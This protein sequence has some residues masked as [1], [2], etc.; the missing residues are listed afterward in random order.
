MI[1]GVCGPEGAGKSTVARILVEHHEA[2]I[3]P[4]AGPL[5]RMLEALG[6]PRENLYGTPEQKAAP[7]DL[8]GGK[9]ARVAM[10]LLGTEWGRDLIDEDLWARCWAQRA[11]LP[12]DNPIVVADDLRF[13]NEV[14]AIR[15]LGGKVIRVVRGTETAAPKHR[16]EDYRAIGFDAEILNDGDLSSLSRKVAETVAWLS[17]PVATAATA[18]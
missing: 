8:L 13:P 12:A 9:S 1:I 11:A 5:K 7:L 6:V 4:F 15:A 17:E 14:T 18:R 10:Q 3:E 16:S 2:R